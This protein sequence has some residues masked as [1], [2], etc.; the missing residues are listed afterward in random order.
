MLIMKL[1]F[2]D[3]AFLSTSKLTSLKNCPLRIRDMSM[4]YLL[5]KRMQCFRYELYAKF[6]FNYCIN[7]SRI[8][9][10][11]VGQLLSKFT[12]ENFPRLSSAFL[13]IEIFL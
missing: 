9:L 5:D 3:L 10:L 6:D 7:V 13:A 2:V 1:Y 8:H 12:H 11:E 4:F